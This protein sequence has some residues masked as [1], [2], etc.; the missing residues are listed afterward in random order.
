MAE[1]KLRKV[2]CPS[3]GAP[4]LFGA[5]EITTRCQFC[6]S[7]VERPLQSDQPAK[8]KDRPVKEQPAEWPPPFSPRPAR[9]PG[10]R[11]LAIMLGLILVA[12]LA[13]LTVFLV[14]EQAIQ[15]GFE[16][17][18]YGPAALLATDS[19]EGPDFIVFSYDRGKEIYQLLRVNPFEGEVIWR[20][21]SFESIS[22]LQRIAVEGAVF[23][24][25][26]GKELHAYHAADGSPLWQTQ[27]SDE[28]GYCEECL[29]I[30]DG[31]AVVLTKD[32]TIEAFDTQSGESAWK[33][34]MDGYTDGFVIADGG[35][36]VID[37]EE[38]TALFR[39]GLADGSIEQ[40]IVPGCSLPDGFPSSTLSA[41]SMFL[42]D[43]D[44]S[45][46]SEDRS[47]YLFYG[48]HPSCIERRDAAGGGRIWQ[49]VEE[50]GFSPSQ[51][52]HSLFTA[53]TMFFA[54]KDTLWSLSKADGQVRNVMEDEDYELV[55][56]ALEQGVLILRTKRTRGT[57]QYGLRGIDPQSG[58]TVW[59]HMMENAE[60]LEPPD[61]A[62]AHV[63]DDR[64]IWTWR[65]I[66]G[67]IRLAVF[68]ANPNRITFD[69]IDPTDGSTTGQETLDLELSGDSYFGPEVVAWKDTTV[70]FI[71]ATKLMAVDI[72]SMILLQSFP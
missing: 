31:R 41:S 23:F 13:V 61:A 4:L 18:V 63:D 26:E 12:G 34:R 29:S 46:P 8:L 17:A 6:N 47:L 60:P 1:S 33:R 57:A 54:D 42:F 16:P 28:L 21:Q 72:S 52:Y 70:W 44:P 35:L 5:G 20:G 38:D 15:L 22:D 45:I 49:T 64:S 39:L 65:L 11:G 71:A 9:S 27:L 68:R 36:W 66:D 51:D 50:D 32:Y 7:V 67:R 40:R 58:A 53:E 10:P 24:T 19:P 43:P 2:A 55:P 14:T 59:D 62:F 69:T 37:T 56:L 25:V 30:A 48:W 3:C